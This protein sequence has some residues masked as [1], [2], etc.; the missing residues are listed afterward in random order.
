[1]SNFIPQRWVP[2]LYDGLIRDEIVTN[3][4]KFAR[5]TRDT[6]QQ[7]LQDTPIKIVQDGDDALRYLDVHP[8][9]AD[10]TTAVVM[11]YP[12]A[13]GNKLSMFLRAKAIE[14]VYGSPLRFL[15]LPN[16]TLT[17]GDPTKWHEFEADSY[18]PV[19]RRIARLGA[20]AAQREG[21]VSVH[22]NGYS[23]AATVAGMMLANSG[24][25][26]HFESA[27]IGDPVDVV[28]RAKKGLKA[29]FQAGGLGAVQALKDAVNHSGVPALSE[30]Q[31]SAPG[32]MS[33]TLQ[34]VDLA[35]FFFST[36]H[37][38]NKQLHEE[39][40]EPDFVEAIGI[41]KHFG[42]LPDA[43]HTLIYRMQK[44]AVCPPKI[45]PI[46]ERHELTAY[47]THEVPHYAHEGGDNI[48][49]GALLGT[50][51]MRGEASVIRALDSA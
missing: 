36:K 2:E 28:K 42:F 25:I 15:L 45:N 35:K 26:V 24:D 13:Q 7:K 27:A 18:V 48:F 12:Y 49:L 14:S 31:H 20:I 30:F 37:P 39:M 16:N 19:K 33:S 23:Q 40:T 10:P 3:Y 44:S 22:V 5:E 9:G 46:F 41:S 11:P 17:A 34:A 38:E 29:D 51:A 32:I 43:D 8:E 21:I 47:M 6:Q 1:M 50:A 4:E